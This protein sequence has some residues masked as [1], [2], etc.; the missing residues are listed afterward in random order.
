M[1]DAKIVGLYWERNQDAIKYTA[2]KYGNYCKAIAKNILGNAEDAEEC[3]NDTYMKT[4]NTIPSHKPNMLS[5]FLGKITRNISFNKYK[6][7]HADKRGGGEIP[8]I[9]DELGECVSGKD[10][11]E[12][13]IEYKEFVEAINE[14]LAGLS[15]EKRDI[16]VC[17]YWYSDSVADIANQFG[18]KEGTVSMA[19]NRLRLKLRKYLEERSFEV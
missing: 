15:K 18:M 8:A 19:L 7:K 16:F 1:E 13:E 10:N 17:R 3:V 14:F 5:T 12:N 2:Q 9:L 6:M 4:W 11:V